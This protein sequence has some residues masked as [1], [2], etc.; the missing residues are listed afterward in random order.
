MQSQSYY[1]QFGYYAKVVPHDA[2][3]NVDTGATID[4]YKNGNENST[5]RNVYQ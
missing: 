2:D 1:F 3:N 4:A 5:T